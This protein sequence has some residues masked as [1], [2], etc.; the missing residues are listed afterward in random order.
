MAEQ[1]DMNRKQEG[2]WQIFMVIFVLVQ[3]NKMK[4]GS[5]FSYLEGQNLFRDFGGHMDSFSDKIYCIDIINKEEILKV[6]ENY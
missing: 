2:I 3:G 4:T 5:G 6:I 1:I